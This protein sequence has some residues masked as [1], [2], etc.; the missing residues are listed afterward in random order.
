MNIKW[1]HYIVQNP[2]QLAMYLMHMSQAVFSIKSWNGNVTNMTLDPAQTASSFWKFVSKW[3][4][5]V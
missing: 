3:M 4:M 1:W 2:D 5:V